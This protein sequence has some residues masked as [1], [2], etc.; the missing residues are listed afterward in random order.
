MLGIRRTDGLVNDMCISGCATDKADAKNNVGGR[1]ICTDS[2][3]KYTTIQLRQ[4][5][6]S[7]QSVFLVR[8]CQ[9]RFYAALLNASDRMPR[10]CTLFSSCVRSIATAARKRIGTPTRKESGG[11]HKKR[12]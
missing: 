3:E 12:E 4:A 1:M 2:E 10:A 8:S 5:T 9:A 7:N 11:Q 6:K